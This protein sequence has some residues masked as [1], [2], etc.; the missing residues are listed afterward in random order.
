MCRFQCKSPDCDHCLT[1]HVKWRACALHQHLCDRRQLHILQ[2]PTD[3]Q[4]REKQTLMCTCVCIVAAP[5]WPC[6][7]TT[8]LCCAAA[9]GLFPI[10]LW[11]ASPG[12]A[13]RRCRLPTGT[14]A[15]GLAV[16]P[17]GWL[18]C[19]LKKALGATAGFAS[20]AELLSCCK[21]SLTYERSEAWTD[22]RPITALSSQCIA[23]NH[24]H[25]AAGID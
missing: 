20:P 10:V 25:K 22:R 13:V 5:D 8:A 3:Q 9:A 24:G 7:Q 15:I 12:L 23:R 6:L 4:D 11:K 14:V 1:R 18:G 2:Y 17:V 16:L 19:A 21:S